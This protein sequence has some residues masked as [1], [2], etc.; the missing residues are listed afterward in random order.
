[1]GVRYGPGEDGG[2][3]GGIVA[4]AAGVLRRRP[5]WEVIRRQRS[6]LFAIITGAPRKVENVGAASPRRGYG[7][8]LLPGVAE[9]ADFV[10]E[11]VAFL[12]GSETGLAFQVTLVP[13]RVPLDFG[14]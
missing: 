1:M 11:R 6:K 9:A 4:Q 2:Y 10:Q 7:L 3:D 5:P 8:L 12:L 13:R 14:G